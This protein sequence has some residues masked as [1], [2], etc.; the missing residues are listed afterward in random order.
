[1]KISK[2]RLGTFAQISADQCTFV[3]KEETLVIIA[4]H[5]DDLIILAEN[6]AEME[7]V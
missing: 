5:V 4:A 2:E 6:E 3:K 7:E 1:M